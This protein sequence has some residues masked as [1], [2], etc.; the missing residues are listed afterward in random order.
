MRKALV[1]LFALAGLQVNSQSTVICG[2]QTATLNAAAVNFTL[3]P[4]ANNY[5][6]NPGGN[7]NP[8][9]VFVIQPATTTNYTMI[10]SNG[11]TTQ[12]IPMTVTVNPQPITSVSLTQL[13]CN[14]TTNAWNFNLSFNPVSPVPSYTIVWDN[15]GAGQPNIPAGWTQP[16]SSGSGSI[17][18]G[19]YAATITANGGCSTKVSFTIN[20]APAP[21]TFSLNPGGA[22]IYSLTCAIPVLTLSV[23]QPTQNYTWAN[24]IS[25]PNTNTEVVLTFSDVATWTVTATNPS[26]GC[27][28]TR[29]FVLA[30]NTLA[31]V[32]SITPTFQTI[33]CSAPTPT[34][35]VVTAVN[36]TVNFTHFI[37][38]PV[39]PMFVANS[40]S[41]AYQPGAHT[42]TYVFLNNVTGCS[43]TTQFTVSS[44]GSNFPTFTLV[45]IPGGYSVGC[46]TKSCV[47]INIVNAQTTPTAGGA[48]SFTILPPGSSSVISTGSLSNISN[49]TFCT[50]GN[51]TAIVKDDNSNCAERRMFSVVQNTAGPSLDSTLISRP[52]PG[53]QG[54]MVDCYTP[55]VSLMGTSELLS[56]QYVWTFPFGPGSQSGAEIIV[57]SN[58]A[59]PTTSFI[60]N[61]TLTM[62]DPNNLCLTKT[63][64]PVYQNL[65]P[66]K[67]K[68]TTGGTFSLTCLTPTIML[69][70]QSTTGIPPGSAF[71]TNSIIAGWLW[72]GP[73]PQLP[74]Q[75][76]SSYVAETPGDYTLTI[77]DYNNGCMTQTFVEVFEFR[78]YPTIN[79]SQ[80][81][82]P[83]P[84]DCGAIQATLEPAY[85]NGYGGT[86]QDLRF[87]YQGPPLAPTS[88]PQNSFS[89]IP[90]LLAGLAG[91]YTITANNPLN[92][93]T[94]VNTMTVINGT[95]TAE[96]SADKNFGY[97][98]L[99]VTFTNYSHSTNS[100]SA[101]TS[102]STWWSF[103]NNSVTTTTATSIQ[104][105]TVYNQP[106]TYT[107]VIY[108][109]KG[110][111]T[112]TATYSINVEI[113]SHLVIPNIFT[114]N[115]DGVND[116][117]FLGTANM[118]EIT[119][120]IYD[121]WGQIVYEL[122][123]S[124][125][126]I[127]WDGLNQSGK[128]V[129]D[130]VYFYVIKATG[131]DAQTYETKGTI[132]LVR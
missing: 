111:C 127:A 79:A 119:A 6:L 113:P 62:T 116:L 5:T 30:S 100:V 14:T 25:A 8:S 1:L 47:A 75:V 124:T 131:R 28:F 102:I 120:Q 18:P 45:S 64:V 35:I 37:Y 67:P 17:A 117:Y 19:V 33:S 90:R 9:G 2:G 84:L 109:I 60:A 16:Q 12:A 122:T 50:A 52:G 87:M 115:G 82:A 4:P 48:V 65:Y 71:Q 77:K 49:Y 92:G 88:P 72:E 132:T 54:G 15:F 73:T 36:P 3:N 63:V 95:L 126:N 23:S 130:G 101:T 61:Y 10:G 125:G 107:A 32:A 41:A 24:N 121:R 20:P 43:M 27:V 22:S 86:T 91:V 42:Y 94:A 59:A 104:P 51:Y 96:F 57:P 89:T 97:A 58:T 98:P 39:G 83:V 38:S 78:K 76:S 118:A 13:S 26:S 81:V 93:C 85:L 53:G 106:G 56:T 105:V 114:P 68:V 103:G 11:T 74:L 70:N 21:A 7:T 128:E 123:S 66:P 40:Q 46:S 112:A 80:S 108:A 110:S 31:P 129:P 44:S 55:T 34:N 29:T 99:E 69:S